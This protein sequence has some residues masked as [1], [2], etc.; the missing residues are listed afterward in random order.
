MDAYAGEVQAMHPFYEFNS[1]ARAK[2][3][4]L[5]TTNAYALPGNLTAGLQH[6]SWS[7]PLDPA[8][9]PKASFLNSNQRDIHDDLQYE[10]RDIEHIEEWVKRHVETTWHSLGTCSMAPKE[11]N[12]IVKHGVLDERL[13]VHGVK[14]LKVADLSICPDNVGCNTYSTALLIGEKCAMLIAED[15]GY[16]GEALEMKVPSYHAP[17]ELSS[18]AGARL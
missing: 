12:S 4:D 15:L 7:L 11:G 14:N 9:P 3:M 1:K 5:A 17:G 18:I 6:G 2:D 13:N 8:K 10:K 16:S